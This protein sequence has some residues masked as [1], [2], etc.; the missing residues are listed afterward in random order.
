LEEL[1][2]PA[3]APVRQR[4]R[5]MWLTKVVAFTMLLFPSSGD[6]EVKQRSFVEKTGRP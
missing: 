1:A 4:G 5:R 3:S 6:E 2:Q